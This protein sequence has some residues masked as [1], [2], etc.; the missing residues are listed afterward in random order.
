MSISTISSKVSFTYELFY[1]RIT[2]DT[3]ELQFSILHLS[4]EIIAPAFATDVY[5][6][7]SK[8]LTNLAEHYQYYRQYRSLY[9]LLQLLWYLKITIL[10]SRTFDRGYKIS[11]EW[12]CSSM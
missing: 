7:D 8:R 2:C 3:L 5:F 11:W 9:Q 1:L 4:I 12:F 10:D 6:I